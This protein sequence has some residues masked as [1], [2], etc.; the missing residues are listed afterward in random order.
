[1]STVM[2]LV[3]PSMWLYGIGCR[4]TWRCFT[5]KLWW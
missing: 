4:N 3:L 5:N 2:V 1:M